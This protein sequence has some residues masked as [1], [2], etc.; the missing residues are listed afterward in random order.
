MATAWLKPVVKAA[1]YFVLFACL[2]AAVQAQDTTKVTEKKS[3]NKSAWRSMR[4]VIW[5][6]QHE[7]PPD[8]PKINP[9]N[10]TVMFTTGPN[11]IMDHTGRPHEPN[12]VIQLLMDG[13]NGLQDPPNKDGSPGGD[14]SLAFG[15][16]NMIR[17]TGRSSRPDTVRTGTFTTKR[18]FVPLYP[19]GRAYYLRVWE[20]TDV[21]TAPYYQDSIEYQSSIDQGGAMIIPKSGTPS[22]ARW[23]FGPSKP[24]PK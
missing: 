20:G 3:A 16:M 18:Y 17:M 2:A 4:P 6:Y 5:D 1:A 13:G 7:F 22:I 14:D 10:I 9:Y 8:F 11:P 24:R 23:K 15:N 12:H 21:A 19:A